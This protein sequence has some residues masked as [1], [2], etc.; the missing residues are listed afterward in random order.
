MTRAV[1]SNLQAVINIFALLA[2]SLGKP[3]ITDATV[4]P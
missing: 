1:E 4:T 3:R 2:T